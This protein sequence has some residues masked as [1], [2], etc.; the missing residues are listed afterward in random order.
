[1]S[2]LPNLFKHTDIPTTFGR[3]VEKPVEKKP[4]PIAAFESGDHSLP[5]DY[6]ACADAMDEA[7][8]QCP[9]MFVSI[10]EKIA[11]YQASSD[12]KLH[13]LA[14]AWAEATELVAPRKKHEAGNAMAEVM[15]KKQEERQ[16]QKM[17]ALSLIAPPKHT[18]TQRLV[19]Y[20]NRK[21]GEICGLPFFTS[22]AIA[23]MTEEIKKNP[24]MFRPGPLMAMPA[25]YQP[26]SDLPTQATM[27]AYTV[28][29]QAAGKP[30]MSEVYRDLGFGQMDIMRD[31]DI[32][33]VVSYLESAEYET[34]RL[35]QLNNVL[36]LACRDAGVTYDLAELRLQVGLGAVGWTTPADMKRILD[37]VNSLPRAPF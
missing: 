4:D 10:E 37:Y 7:V 15:R 12:P 22:E 31:Q 5:V 20:A 29:W 25:P 34:K 35:V 32:R 17:Q 8:P 3:K 24:E 9:E 13:L 27:D 16:K 1:M 36:F 18:G 19:E 30:D 11:L 33:K 6:E 28:A 21:L 2:L 23:K 26:K 14:A